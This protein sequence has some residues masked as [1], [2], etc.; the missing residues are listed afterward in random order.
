MFAMEGGSSH[1]ESKINFGIR[2][3][4]GGVAFN[5]FIGCI[6]LLQTMKNSERNRETLSAT[7]A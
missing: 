1:G 7:A 3:S 2:S 4:S 6:S 5:R